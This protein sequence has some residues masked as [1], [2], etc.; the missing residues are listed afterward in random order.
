MSDGEPYTRQELETRPDTFPERGLLCPRCNTRIPE[1]AELS[2]SD[3]SRIRRL[4]SQ[5]QKALAMDEL[6]D[7]TGCSTR[8][9]KIWVIHSG[10]PD[11]VG[12]TAPCPYCGE[13][14][15]TALAR[16]CQHCFMAWHD[17]DRPYDLRTNQ[18][19]QDGESDS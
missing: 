4:I 5:N 13:Q 17:P 1:F 3:A 19:Q 14:L 9:A 16:Q 11:S 10:R 2:D 8:F 7:A 12:T 18:A 15:V 6:E